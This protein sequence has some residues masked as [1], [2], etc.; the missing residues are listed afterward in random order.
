MGQWLLVATSIVAFGAAPLAAG[1][2]PPDDAVTL[3]ETTLGVVTTT[4]PPGCP[5]PPVAAAVFLGTMIASDATTARFRVDQLRA[6]SLEGW[7]VGGLV[8]VDLLD[9]TRYLDEDEQYLVGVAPDPVTRRL[10]SKVGEAAPLFGGNQVVG[11]NDGGSCPAQKDPVRTIHPDGSGVESG[12]LH[13]LMSDKSGLAR[14]LLMPAAWA[15]LALV[16][17]ATAKGL[18]FGSGREALR[19]LRREPRIRDEDIWRDAGYGDE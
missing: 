2:A 11:V 10:T 14:A 18:V 1:A 16:I 7:Q 12:L 5:E 8:D 17:L 6:G 3:P 15:F 4:L 9:D 13:P 19:I